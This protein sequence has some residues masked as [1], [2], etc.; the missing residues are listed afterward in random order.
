MSD[1]TSRL[2]PANDNG[3]TTLTLIHPLIKIIARQVAHDHAGGTPA[4]DNHVP[5]SNSCKP[6]MSG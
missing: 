5:G 3:E 4:N 1:S 2:T 6:G